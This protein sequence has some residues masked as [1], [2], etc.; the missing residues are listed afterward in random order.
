[1][2][3]LI[4]AY[5]VRAARRGNGPKS[6]PPNADL[7]TTDVC[8]ERSHSV[9]IAFLVLATLYG[10]TLPLK[11]SLVLIDSAVLITIFVVYIVRIA[12]APAEEPHLVGPAQLVGTL[13]P[14]T[15]RIVV[16]L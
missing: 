15:R 4:A 1:M 14:N 8:L 10:L 16:G 3:V 5:R 13:A 2:V 6:L 11:S 9:E 7:S 12:R